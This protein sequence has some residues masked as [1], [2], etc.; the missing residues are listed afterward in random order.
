MPRIQSTVPSMSW[1]RLLLLR[2][3]RLAV[4]RRRGSNGL[5]RFMRRP[6]I[7]RT[8]RLASSVVACCDMCRAPVSKQPPSSQSQQLHHLCRIIIIIKH[9]SRGAR[10]PSP[11][12]VPLGRWNDGLRKELGHDLLLRKQAV[13]PDTLQTHWSI[14]AKCSGGVCQVQAD[15]GRCGFFISTHW[16]SSFV[17]PRND[18]WQRQAY[19]A[20]CA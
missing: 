9:I 20:I 5:Q 10:P 18:A 7:V 6:P 17:S 3:R 15:R 19:R 1:A 4:W 2:R 12:S 14:F 8:R 16:P 13:R 11:S